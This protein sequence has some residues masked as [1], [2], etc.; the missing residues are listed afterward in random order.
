VVFQLVIPFYA[1]S[2]VRTLY[3]LCCYDPLNQLSGPTGP[4]SRNVV[5]VITV[6][7]VYSAQGYGEMRNA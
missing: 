1:H 5:R 3:K 6:K 7:S 4:C 2:S